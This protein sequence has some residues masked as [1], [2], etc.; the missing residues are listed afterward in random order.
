M[1]LEGALE[2]QSVRLFVFNT[3]GFCVEQVGM[4]NKVLTDRLVFS[5]M[6][7]HY[8]DVSVSSDLGDAFSDYFSLS[9]CDKE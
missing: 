6:Y 8:T 5:L 9:E 7:L 4:N 2:I 1:S 3:G